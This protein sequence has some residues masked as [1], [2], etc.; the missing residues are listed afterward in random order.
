MPRV[1]AAHVSAADR[2]SDNGRRR[3]GLTVVLIAVIIIVVTIVI[4]VNVVVNSITVLGTIFATVIVVTLLLVIITVRDNRFVALFR[5]H[6]HA[7]VH[8][9]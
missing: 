8:V 6:L 2:W 3:R 4:S 5:R 7:G 1:A 9:R